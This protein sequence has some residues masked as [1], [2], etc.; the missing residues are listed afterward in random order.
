MLNDLTDPTPIGKVIYMGFPKSRKGRGCSGSVF[1]CA[2]YSH[3]FCW[4]LWDYER[5]A[6]YDVRIVTL[7]LGLSHTVEIA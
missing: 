5:I 7:L 3:F 4:R 2:G 1:P 6:F